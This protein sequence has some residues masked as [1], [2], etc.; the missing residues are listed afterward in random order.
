M[1]LRPIND[2][3]KSNRSRERQRPSLAFLP[4]RLPSRFFKG[5]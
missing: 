2:N 3:E 5:V 1:G 4:L